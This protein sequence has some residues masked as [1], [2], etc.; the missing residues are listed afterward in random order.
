VMIQRRK[1][2]EFLQLYAKLTAEGLTPVVVKGI[3]CRNLYR[4]PDYRCSGDEDVLIPGE[5][6]EK[7][8]ELFLNN[9]MNQMD[10]TMNI[11]EEGEV[12]YYRLGGA[13]HIELHK[14]LFSSE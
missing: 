5:Q 10:P 2:E 13:L 8:H 3:V 11:R 9:G 1:T 7:C 4:E 14:V 12:L 6:F